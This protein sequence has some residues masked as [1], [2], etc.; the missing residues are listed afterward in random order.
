M[1]PLHTRPERP[2]YL[3]AAI[4]A[5]EDAWDATGLPLKKDSLNSMIGTFDLREDAVWLLRSSHHD[6]DLKPLGSENSDGLRRSRLR[7]ARIN[8]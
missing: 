3:K 2:N 6:D 4:A 8:L 5:M 1:G 7:R